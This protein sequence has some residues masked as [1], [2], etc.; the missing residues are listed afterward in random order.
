MISRSSGIERRKIRFGGAAR[1]PRDEHTFFVANAATAG[2]FGT[3]RV[4]KRN[5][6]LSTGQSAWTGP[7]GGIL[8]LS[9]RGR[10]RSDHAQ[11]DRRGKRE[12]C[13]DRHIRLPREGVA[14]MHWLD[15]KGPGLFR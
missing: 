4:G 7:I 5:R 9:G 3:V 1:L 2:G 15:T 10:C 14:R 11:S 6:A 13:A 12:L 8:L